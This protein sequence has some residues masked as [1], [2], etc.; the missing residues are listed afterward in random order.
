M[1]VHEIRRVVLG[2]TCF[3][4]AE[5]SL[6][7]ALGIAVETGGELH[8]LLIEE[9]TILV[10]S[11][12]PAARTISP[13]G[14]TRGSP[15]LG[16]MQAAFRQDASR[17]EES[18]SRA[19]AD[20]AVRWRFSHRPG[21]LTAVLSEETSAGDLVLLSGEPLQR[22]PGEIVLLAGNGWDGALFAVAA[23]LARTY[24][25]RLR[26]LRP[27]Q[28]APVPR[29][30]PVPVL[31]EDLSGPGELAARLSRLG[32]SSLLVADLADAAPVLGRFLEH[33]RF[34]RLLRVRHAEE[35]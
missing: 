29:D 3:A 8:G 12:N 32:A 31:V 4:D 11:G 1:R 21:R 24:H 35:G 17:F 25:S 23:G 22:E 18:L 14:E 30:L 20:R 13:R 16:R 15:G 7:I 33:A 6:E 9:E 34:P 27:A 19:A 26:I 28:A 5:S 10:F 2:A